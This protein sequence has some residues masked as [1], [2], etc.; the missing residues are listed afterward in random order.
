MRL[1]EDSDEPDNLLV[2]LPSSETALTGVL[3]KRPQYAAIH[4]PKAMQ[5]RHP[6]SMPV[7]EQLK[8]AAMWK[9]PPA[10]CPQS[11][12][13]L[14]CSRSLSLALSLSRPFARALAR[15]RSLSLSRSS[16]PSSSPCPSLPSPSLSPVELAYLLV[17]R[18]KIRCSRPDFI[19]SAFQV[20]FRLLLPTIADLV[21]PLSSFIVLA[22]AST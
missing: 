13:P 6:I 3:A 17:E 10:R 15:L 16:S 8:L 18:H 7:T 11:L 22:S 12:S 21:R 2:R 9:E 5:Q 19:T 4:V 20:A 1:P 14:S